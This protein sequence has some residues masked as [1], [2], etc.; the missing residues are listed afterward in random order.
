MCSIILCIVRSLLPSSRCLDGW[1][2]LA[3]VIFAGRKQRS[4]EVNTFSEEIIRGCGLK[5][6]KRERE[7]MPPQRQEQDR[8]IPPT[9]KQQEVGV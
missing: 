4:L 3:V 5:V 9:K 7:K 6:R 8:D 2:F 1:E